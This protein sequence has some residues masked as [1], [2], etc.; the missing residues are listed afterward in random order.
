MEGTG[1][2]SG[3]GL[4]RCTILVGARGLWLPSSDV[5]DHYSVP[6]CV[7]IF[8]RSGAVQHCGGGDESGGGIRGSDAAVWW[9]AGEARGRQHHGARI[10]HE[11]NFPAPPCLRV[12]LM[13]PSRFLS[14]LS[15][16]VREV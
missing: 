11:V 3:G 13:S 7:C 16:V 2:D 14:T 4:T 9:A 15:Y 8:L 12:V 6:L 10:Y 1:S 5:P